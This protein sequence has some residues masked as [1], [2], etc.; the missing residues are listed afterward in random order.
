MDNRILLPWKEKVAF[1]TFMKWSAETE[2]N[3]YWY[4]VFDQSRWWRICATNWMVMLEILP[5]GVNVAPMKS[6]ILLQKIDGEQEVF[7]KNIHIPYKYILMMNWLSTIKVHEEIHKSWW[8]H[9]DKIELISPTWS[10]R[11]R[12][13]DFIIDKVNSAFL[14]KPSIQTDLFWKEHA[15]VKFNLAKY[16][17]TFDKVLKKLSDEPQFSVAEDLTTSF[18]TTDNN[19]EYYLVTKTPIAQN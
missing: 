18:W 16:K 2:W 17:E 9:Y 13:E 7:E 5:C 12:I 1:D 4:L 14:E 10:T 19:F 8:L 11:I 6:Y 3:E 15:S